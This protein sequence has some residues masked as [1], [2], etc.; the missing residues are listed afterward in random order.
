MCIYLV[1]YLAIYLV[2]IYLVLYPAIYLAKSSNYLQYFG[3]NHI[4]IHHEKLKCG[5]TITYLNLNYN[6]MLNMVL[7]N[8]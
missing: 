5:C 6:F 3:F 4:N 2:I 8:V 1:V 7:K